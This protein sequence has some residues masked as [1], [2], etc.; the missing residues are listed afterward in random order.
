MSKKKTFSRASCFLSYT[1]VHILLLT[2]NRT[3]CT[4]FETS[5]VS[6]LRDY[7]HQAK[8]GAKSKKKQAKKIK[9]QAKNQRIN[10]KHQIK[11]MISFPL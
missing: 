9:E 1:K 3:I 10:Y 5:S 6:I 2:G 7:S 4:V 8:V 11:F